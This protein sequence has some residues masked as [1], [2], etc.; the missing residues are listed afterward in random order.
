MFKNLFK[1]KDYLKPDDPT[2][3]T[4]DLG[5]PR[6]KEG[7][8]TLLWLAFAVAAGVAATYVFEKH[9]DEIK[10]ILNPGL[11]AECMPKVQQGEYKDMDTCEKSLAYL[12]RY[13]AQMPN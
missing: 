8:K 5:A 10:D 6:V 2:L 9:G 1:G 3:R 4:I 12:D 13:N 7:N 11:E